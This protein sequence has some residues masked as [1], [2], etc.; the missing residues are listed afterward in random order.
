MRWTSI[1]VA[2]TLVGCSTIPPDPAAYA[3]QHERNVALAQNLGY[4]V[5]TDNGQ[6]RFCATRAPTASHIVAPCMNESQWAA[7]HPDTGGSPNTSSGA[8]E[9]GRS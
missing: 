3:R 2:A 4:E 9:S 6:T 1:L 5:V 8:V 7:L